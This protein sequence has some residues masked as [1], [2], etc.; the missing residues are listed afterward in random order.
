MEVRLLIDTNS[1]IALLNE[2]ADVIAA[3][4]T[5]DD[6]IIS[7]INEIE[8]KSFPNL[9]VNDIKLFDEFI[10][11]IKVLDISANNLPLKNKIIEIRNMYR[12]KL[13]DA[14]IAACA[15]VNNAALVTGD[16]AFKKVNGLKLIFIP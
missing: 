15:I 10:G 13:P 6:I 14:I 5:A 4:E 9:S 11:K 2:N 16:K 1:I 3:V 8:F 12:L 7:I